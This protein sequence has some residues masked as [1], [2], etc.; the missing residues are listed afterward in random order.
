M[1]RIPT[2]HVF[3]I[4]TGNCERVEAAGMIRDDFS[5][6]HRSRSRGKNFLYVEVDNSE[7]YGAERW[8]LN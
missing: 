3:H 8:L 7:F 5:V 4:L 6:H 2:E 1:C